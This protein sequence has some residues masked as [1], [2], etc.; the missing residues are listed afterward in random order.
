MYVPFNELPDSSRIWIYQANRI[1]KDNELEYV[2]SKANYFIENWKRHGED[3]KASFVINYHQFLILGVDEQF[4][5]VSGCSIDSSVRFIKDLETALQVDFTDK[6]N[7]TFKEGDVISLVQ[8]SEFQEQVE[9]GKLSSET[10][11]FN[12][13]IQLKEELQTKW[14]VPVKDSWHNRFVS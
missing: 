1:L 9:Q 3:L 4:N 10:I 13:M 12:N 8:L 14:E 5:S 7:V 11:V 2:S 6:L